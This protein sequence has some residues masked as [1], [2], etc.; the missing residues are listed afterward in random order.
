MFNEKDNNGIDF[1][2]FNNLVDRGANNSTHSDNIGKNENF[3][4]KKNIRPNLYTNRENDNVNASD[5]RYDNNIDRNENTNSKKNYGFGG[6]A[7]QEPERHK[8]QQES[9][10][11]RLKSMYVINLTTTRMGI[12]I[13]SICAIF[14]IIFIVGFQMG[15]SKSENTVAKSNTNEELLFRSDA[16][17]NIIT[18]SEVNVANT[19]NQNNKPFTVSE[20]TRTDIVSMDLL[21][22]NRSSGNNIATD[23][24]TSMI[25]RD[26]EDLGKSLNNNNNSGSQSQSSAVKTLDARESRASQE[27][28]LNSYI[29]S[30]PASYIP[31]EK[32]T[33]SSSVLTSTPKPTTTKTVTSSASSS[34][35]TSKTSEN[36]LVYYIQVAVASTEKPVNIERDYLRSK[37][38]IKAYVIDGVGKDGE[39]MYKLKIGRYATRAQAESALASLKALSSKYSDSYIYTDKAS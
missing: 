26:L 30:S 6:K 27:E 37:D 22:D 14:L 28:L 2:K 8:E 12:V 9:P 29:N 18:G 4:S 34:S 16:A 23:D 33:A 24:I 17:Q 25:N 10:S 32:S 1:D 38:F 21:A 13:G 39:V 5:S 15:S 3:H 11:N 20:P 7:Q 31:G 35:S 19:I 36:S